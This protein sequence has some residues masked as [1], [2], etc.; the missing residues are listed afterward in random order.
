MEKTRRLN[1]SITCLILIMLLFSL[2]SNVT[3]DIVYASDEIQYSNVLV[4]L[5]KDKNF[6]EEDFPEIENDYSLK[7]IQ[8][9]ESINKELF[10][11]V[12]QPAQNKD[13]QA[14]SVNISTEKSNLNYKNYKLEL[15]SSASTLYKFKV[16]NFEIKADTT[17]YY[18]MSSIFRNW[19]ESI[20][21][22]PEGDNTISE[23]AFSVNKLWIVQNVDNQTIYQ[24]LETETI[25]I[26][27]K[28]VGFCRYDSGANFWGTTDYCDSHFVAFSTDREIDKLMEADVYF[29][30]Q[31]V[32]Y[33]VYGDEWTFGI[34][35]D[36]YSYMTDKSAVF[37]KSDKNFWYNYEYNWQRIQ[38]TGDFIAGENFSKV[39]KGSF[40][41]VEEKYTMDEESKNLIKD[42]QWVLRFFESTYTFTP[43][44]YGG[45]EYYVNVSNVSILRL[46][47]KSLNKV[48]DL[49][50]I[51]N[52]QTGD[53]EP[54][55]K[56]TTKTSL[57]WW[58]KI[59]IIIACIIVIV[60]FAPWIIQ[61]LF[62]IL[63]W[64]LKAVWWVLTLPFEIFKD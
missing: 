64:V 59:L 61:I 13:L 63:W 39:Y 22:T 53:G 35:E 5:K 55:N 21:E 43:G 50:V 9:A 36:N 58:L 18:D 51:D 26:T 7:V 16:L 4:D 38:S 31:S 2:V 45:E 19:Q 17:R 29:Q 41:N 6:N 44:W 62:K 12:Y 56:Y 11:Y 24:C 34:I 8:I 33:N 52:K 20:D 23:V 37:Y 47:F 49:G 32:N 28:Y 1:F 54:D 40:F 48:Y 30:T 42:K 27:D 46:K 57:S 10:I 15:L 25:E 3:Q 14:T 60:I